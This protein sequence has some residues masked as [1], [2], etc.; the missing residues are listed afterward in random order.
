MTGDL[1]ELVSSVRETLNRGPQ[2]SD[3]WSLIVA[4]AAIVFI[5]WLVT[6]L[7]R[8]PPEKPPQPAVDFFTLACN[9][10]GLSP[11]ERRD[12]KAL[13][14]SG[15]ISHPAR[16]VLSPANLAQA[17]RASAHLKDDEFRSRMEVLS[18][19]LFNEPLPAVRG[20]PPQ[21]AGPKR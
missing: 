6:R 10:L 7:T 16:I 17:L 8:K 5:A 9:R 1:N 18:Q 13:A 19:R 14:E 21:S 15:M 2:A 20:E 12:L 11:Q 4:P 3:G